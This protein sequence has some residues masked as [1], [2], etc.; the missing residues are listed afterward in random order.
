MRGC[1]PLSGMA[2]SAVA[3]IAYTRFDS[4]GLGA[5]MDGKQRAVDE[6]SPPGA[7]GNRGRPWISLLLAIILAVAVGAAAY[8]LRGVAP[9]WA[10]LAGGAAALLGL[11]TLFG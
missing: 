2:D 10:L 8:I 11:F 9:P 3:Q 7:A 5:Q 1:K 6:A 4:V